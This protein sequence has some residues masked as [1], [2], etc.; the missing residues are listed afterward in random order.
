MNASELC[1]ERRPPLALPCRIFNSGSTM[2]GHG[3]RAVVVA[4]ENGGNYG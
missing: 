2:T 1:S 3:G 4:Q